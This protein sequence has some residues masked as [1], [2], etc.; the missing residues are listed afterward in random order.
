MAQ[1]KEKKEE[2]SFET[3]MARIE[4]IVGT[5]EK[6]ELGLEQEMELYREASALLQQC[7]KTLEEAEL[8]F[9]TIQ[10]QKENEVSHES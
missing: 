8:E 7:N 6:G 5:L 4:E 1:A 2:K 9:R 3:M 10:D